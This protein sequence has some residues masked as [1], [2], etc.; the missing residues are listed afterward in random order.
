MSATRC[1][2]SALPVLPGEV[3]L[4][5]AREVRHRG[6]GGS[7][8]G[9]LLCTNVRVA[10]VPGAQ[11]PSF[12]PFLQSDYSVALRCIRTLVAAS[13]FTKPTVLTASSTLTFI[14]EELAVFCQDFRLLRFHFPENGLGLQAFRVRGWMAFEVANAIA[15]ARETATW[16][17]DSRSH[18]D[19]T[20]GDDE[21]EGSPPTLLFESLQDWERELQRLGAVGWRVS[22]VNERFDMAA[23]LPRYLWVPSTLLDHDL[24]RTFAHFQERRVARL[25]WHHPNGSDLLR[26]AGFHAA[27]EPGSEDIRCLEVLL[28]AGCRPCVLADTAELPSPP[29]IQLAHLRLQA[30]CLPGAA[31]DEKW[32]SAL[33]GTRWLEHVRACL[34]KAVEVASLLAGKWCSV[35][36]QEP[37]DRDLSCLLASLVQLLAD[38]H[39]RTLHGFQSLVQREWVAAG[40]PFPQRL[41][42][43]RDSP[44]EESPVFLLFL[45]CTWQLLRQFPAAFGFTEAYLLALHD[46]TFLP[47]CSTFL[48]SC[49][50]QR[51]RGGVQQPRTQTYTPVSGRWDPSPGSSTCRLPPVWA[52]GLHYSRQ[53]QARFWNPAWDAGPVGTPDAVDPQN[54]GT[55]ASAWSGS[56]SG[57]VLSLS[58]GSLTPQPFP[59]RS[60]RLP[61]RLLRW[62]PSLETLSD[63][64]GDRIPT[65]P[66]G[67]LLP[68]AAGPSVRLWRRCYLRGLPEAQVMGLGDSQPLVSILIPH[69]SIPTP[70]IHPTPHVTNPVPHSSIPPQCASIPTPC[71]HSNPMYILPNPTCPS[72]PRECPSQSHV[73]PSNPMCDHPN[74]VYPPIPIPCASTSTP[75]N[76]LFASHMCPSNPMFPPHPH[77]HSSQPHM[78]LSNPTCLHPNPAVPHPDPTYPP[79]HGRLAPCPALLVEELALL[80]DRLCAWQQD[81]AHAEPASSP[82]APSR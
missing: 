77:V 3:V 10:F 81:R 79:Q 63:R 55:P 72:H 75:H 52:W 43:C 30:L 48:F 82:L 65:P 70:C 51:G 44:R 36:L 69:R 33:E 64:G 25:C 62:A 45:D 41:G 39:A 9:T 7:V 50:R 1:G 12:S 38:P 57:A 8:R 14:P 46:S 59:W 29:D 15:E 37:S 73:C 23:S 34:R 49:Q 67:L 6:G 20:M 76:H 68:C 40:H 78:C 5:A 61:P 42:L 16:P 22:A 71:I 60:G 4:E 58:K 54:K 32:L 74:P 27:S 66:R 28:G 21:E 17:G 35:V 18:V 26:A 47:Y 53:Q 80:Q 24:K 31:A 11:P 19:A 13:S 56:S 2:L